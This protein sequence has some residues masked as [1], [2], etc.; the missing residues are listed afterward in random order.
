M[1]CLEHKFF[2]EE[3]K[4]D[5]LKKWSFFI[6]KSNKAIIELSLNKRYKDRL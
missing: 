4:K 5:H 1:L 3:H 6:S 2:S